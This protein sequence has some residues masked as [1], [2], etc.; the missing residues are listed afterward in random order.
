MK[1]LSVSKNWKS[2]LT[3]YSSLSLIANIL[4]A[5]SVSG[6]AVLGVLSSEI[7]FTTILITAITLGVLGLI[8]R[9]LDESI[10]DGLI[11]DKEDV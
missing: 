10:D 11:G 2:R 8:G 7:A 1:K 5:L 3:S 6:L 9:V 4:T